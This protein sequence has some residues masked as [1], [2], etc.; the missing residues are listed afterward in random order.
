MAKELLDIANL[1]YFFTIP[2][3]LEAW[4]CEKHL[5]L[6]LRSFRSYFTHPAAYLDVW[7]HKCLLSDNNLGTCVLAASRGYTYRKSPIISLD[8]ILPGNTTCCCFLLF[9]LFG[10]CVCVCVCARACVHAC[11]RVSCVSLCV[12]CVCVCVCVCCVKTR[13]QYEMLSI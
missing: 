13:P 4:L 10:V 7:T 6:Y 3:S 11:V 1:I 9:F 8:V 5:R 12:C 2:S